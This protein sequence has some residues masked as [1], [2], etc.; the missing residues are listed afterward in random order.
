M[1][2]SW[3]KVTR[4]LRTGIAS[5][6]VLC[7]VAFAAPAEGSGKTRQDSVSHTVYQGQTLGMIARRYNVSIAAICSANGIRRNR[8]I[9]PGQKLLIPQK[10]RRSHSAS[11]AKRTRKI[12]ANRASSRRSRRTSSRA[13]A[14]RRRPNPKGPYARRPRQYGRVVLESR[15]GRWRGI[16]VRPDGTIPPSARD[17]FERS[18][19]SWRTGKTE[20]IHG[21]LI[22]M[23]T[24]VSDHFGGRSIEIVS[25]FRPP[26]KE[27]YTLRSKHNIGRAADFRIRGVPNSVIR[28]FCRTL[29][30]VGVGYYP[31][32]T[33]V[34]L[35]IREYSAYWVDFSGPGEPPRYATPSGEDPARSKRRKTRRTARI[36]STAKGA[37]GHDSAG[38]G[39]TPK[40]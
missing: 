21:R 29:P 27:Q 2:P 31:N 8:P 19:A 40:G 36:K 25:G 4:Y 28:D 32:S 34:H 15:T 38:S 30:K 6:V 13:S 7:T 39:S 23:L 12:G 17:G 9:H 26:R 37:D 22:R 16:A 14:P 10:P 3:S 11:T 1:A 5:S 24:R 35:D 33:F 18:L 20:R